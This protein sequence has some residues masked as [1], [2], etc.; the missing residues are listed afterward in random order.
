MMEKAVGR[1]E[2]ERGGAETA[3]V[4]VSASGEVLEF[5]ARPLPSERLDLRILSAL[6]RIIRAVDIYSKHLATDYGLTVP[7]LLCML[8]IDE[9]GA[10]TVKDLAHEIYLN[11]STVVGIVDRLE[12]SGCVQRVRSVR[13]RRS[14]RLHLTEKG[15][16]LL[17]RAPSPMQEQLT[18][19]IEA[20]PELEALT[21]AASLDKLLLLMDN[22]TPDE[23]EVSEMAA[24]PVLETHTELHEP[25]LG[26]D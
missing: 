26:D 4:A 16:E 6:R 1:V 23:L 18:R 14:V 8:K 25:R 3:G 11:P 24:E 21:I 5:G 10:P 2:R 12:K 15:V 7:Q 19:A 22:S 9:L 20:L 17:E 13:D